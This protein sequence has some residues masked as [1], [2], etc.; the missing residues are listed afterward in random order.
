MAAMRVEYLHDRIQGLKD[1]APRNG[2]IDDLVSVL[3]ICLIPKLSPTQG[4]ANLEFFAV[5]LGNRVE[6]SL[7]QRIERLPARFRCIV[8]RVVP[9][10]Q[11]FS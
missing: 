11:K 6:E 1:P 5:F 8:P 7:T 4:S 10:S 3:F 2:G 9:V